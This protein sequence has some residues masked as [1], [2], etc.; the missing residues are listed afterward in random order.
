MC[1]VCIFNSKETGECQSCLSVCLSV[2]MQVYCVTSFVYNSNGYWKVMSP[3]IYNYGTFQLL[4]AKFTLQD[5]EQ[6][7]HVASPAVIN[8]C[9]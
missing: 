4:K 6:Y 7:F 9:V 3:Y 8:H 5:F 2:Y 1:F